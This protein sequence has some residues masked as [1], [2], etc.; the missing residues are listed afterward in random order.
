MAVKT[1]GNPAI[2]VQ[3]ADSYFYTS[4]KDGKI[5][6][7]SEKLS[8]IAKKMERWY[9]V[10]IK[11]EKEALKNF[12]FSG[13]ILRNKPI[14]QTIMAMELLAPIRFHYQV[15]PK[16]KNLITIVGK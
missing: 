1:D 7:N 16:E 14:D 12:N 5:T 2:Q 10:E 3:N 11:F 8:E 6:F 9:N 15:R 13:T 4:W